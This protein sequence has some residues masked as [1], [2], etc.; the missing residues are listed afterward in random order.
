MVYGVNVNDL[1][2]LVFEITSDYLGTQLKPAC[3]LVAHCGDGMVVIVFVGVWVAFILQG[4]LYHALCLAAVGGGHTCYNHVR[5]VVAVEY[6]ESVVC[7]IRFECLSFGM[8]GECVGCYSQ[9]RVGGVVA[10]Q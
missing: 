2:A 5:Q 10:K 6:D 4:L 3:A 8:V 1:F 9:G 7:E